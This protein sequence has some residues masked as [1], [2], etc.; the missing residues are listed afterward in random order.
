LKVVLSQVEQRFGVPAQEPAPVD[1]VQPMHPSPPHSEVGHE[2]QL[3][4]VVVPVQLEPCE[5]Q[6]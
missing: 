1:S 3:V 2:A 5:M 4:Y 6:P